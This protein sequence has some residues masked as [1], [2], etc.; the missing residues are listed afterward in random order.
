MSKSLR[1]PGNRAMRQWLLLPLLMVLG[2]GSGWAQYTKGNLVVLQIGNPT[3]GSASSVT[4]VEY[5]TAGGSPVTSLALPT[6]TAV[7][8]SGVNRRLT[9][10]GNSSTEGT[11]NLSADGRYL[12]L[13]GYDANVGASVGS[14][15]RVVARINNAQTINTTTVLSASV[16]YQTNIRSAVTSNGIDIWTS[17]NGTSTGGGVRYTTLGATDG[18]TQLSNSPTDTRVVSIYDGKLYVSSNT[19]SFTG[20]SAVGSGLPTT[21]G[22][23]TLLLVGNPNAHA[24]VLLDRDPTIPGVD[25]L[26]IAQEGSGGGILK[27]SYD[28]T[29]WTARGRRNGTIRGLTGVINGNSVDLYSTI[30]ESVPNR[31]FKVTDAAPFSATITGDGTAITSGTLVATAASGTLFRGVAFAPS[32]PAAPVITNTAA[33]L[34]ACVGNPLT[35]SATCPT[36]GTVV[37]NGSTTASTLAITSVLTG[38]TSYSATCVSDAA[39]SSVTTTTVTGVASPTVTLLPN[40]ALVTLGSTFQLTATSGLTSYTF[41]GPGISETIQ[42]SNTLNVTN[43]AIANIGTF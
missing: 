33:Q 38:T 22:Q 26:Y 15:D 3:S 9:I 36:G 25:V 18:G 23:T 11:L 31:L 17:G 20:V 12:T 5:S 21:S 10:V 39:S 2:I 19:G 43:V 42:T 41:A 24:F 35:L 13:V 27:Y 29:N 34:T 28:G 4:L 1:L 14:A 32:E 16:A 40:P 7:S 30:V 8:G 37:W 6:V